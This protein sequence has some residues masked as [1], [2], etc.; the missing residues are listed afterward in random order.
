MPIIH[1][2]TL[3]SHLQAS[4][5]EAF[6]RQRYLPSLVAGLQRSGRWHSVQLLRRSREQEGD[7]LDLD[8]QFLLLV[9]GDGVAIEHLLSVDDPTIQRL[10]ESFA[11][12]IVLVGS[13]DVIDT[14]LNEKA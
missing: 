7:P 5:F 4:S 11:P 10:F 14:V 8:R 12:E 13:F 9:E 2:L 6:A 1:R 3:G